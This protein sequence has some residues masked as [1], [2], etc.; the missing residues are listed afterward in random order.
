M[1]GPRRTTLGAAVTWTAGCESLV[2]MSDGSQADASRGRSNPVSSFGSHDD[3][4]GGGAPDPMLINAGGRRRC[5]LHDVRPER[6]GND[7]RMLVS[8]MAGRASIELKGG[9]S[10]STSR[11]TVR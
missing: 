4:M 10:A 9:S 1:T 8:D 3:V 6:V 2:P 5:A 7:M 11:R